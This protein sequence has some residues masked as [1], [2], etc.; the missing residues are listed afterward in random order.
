MKK[1]TSH[2]LPTIFLCFLA[3]CVFAQPNLTDEELD[4]QD[5]QRT[6]ASALFDQT[7]TDSRPDKTV[8][9][10]LS[11][12]DLDD[13]GMD[14]AWE[15]ANGL[16]PSNPKDAWWD[17]DAD[18]ILNLFEFQLTADPNDANDPSVIEVAPGISPADF[19]QIIED[20]EFNLSVI[21][22]SEGEYP[23]SGI[24]V[25]NNDFRV[26]IQGG[27]NSNFT[28]H[29]PDLYTTTMEVEGDEALRILTPLDEGGINQSALII[30]GIRFRATDYFSLGGTVSI[31]INSGNSFVC[32]KDCDMSEGTY[33]GLGLGHKDLV[34]SAAVFLVN[35]IFGN[36]LKG[37]IYSQNTDDTYSRWRMYNNT[38]HNPGSPEGGIDGLTLFNGEWD[39][40]FINGINWGNGN[41]AFNFSSQHVIDIQLI[42][43][44]ADLIS[45]V[46]VPVTTVNSID[47]DPLFQDPVNHVWSLMMGSPCVD[48]GIDVGLP[49][50]GAAPDM[51]AVEL[52]TMSSTTEM[53]ALEAK[54]FPNPV[55]N[56]F[57]IAMEE[58]IGQKV[59]L[60]IFNSIGELLYS[61]VYTHSGFET[62]DVSHLPNGLLMLSLK[63]DGH[64]YFAKI[65]KGE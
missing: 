20:A 63:A 31:S 3:L 19:E 14:D 46:P 52:Q 36:N 29:N 12:T 4:L 9:T 42:H 34:D 5:K 18:Q 6:L 13:D 22:L 35:N 38:I 17:A 40:E 30:E 37:G 60:D 41:L 11:P 64:Q 61:D 59:Q 1:F 53:A 43:S 56:H 8:T 39:I 28:E 62:I 32:I 21:R 54:I 16:D 65:L 33:Y 27:W 26:M 7:Q 23:H 57:S 10:R 48:A 49:Y 47:T 58:L 24:V 51:G 25:Y 55:S 44:D 45:Q 50:S 2:F 15:A